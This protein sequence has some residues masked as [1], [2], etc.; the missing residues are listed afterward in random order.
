MAKIEKLIP[1]IFKW[2]GGA[3]NDPTDKGGATN[4]GLTLS[5]WKS[6][7]YDKDGDGDIDINDL[8]IATKQDVINI[9]R[10]HYWNRWLADTITSQSIANFLVDWLW[11]SGSYA[12]KVPQRMLGVKVD[13]LV[14]SKTIAQLNSV[15]A[16]NFFNALKAERIAFV[17]NIVKN[18]P[19][20]DKF[21]KGWLNRINSFVYAD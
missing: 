3:V 4:M 21:I 17:N 10:K 14:G 9:L 6:M 19:T 8:N 5:T 12:I 13:G 20:Q 2:E 15:N 7:G 18:D 16:R 1:I 11:N